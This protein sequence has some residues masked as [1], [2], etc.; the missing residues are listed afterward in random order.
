MFDFVRGWLNG[1]AVMLSTIT[2]VLSNLVSNVPAVLLLE[3]LIAKLTQPEAAWLTLAATSTLAGNLTLIGS[4]ANL[5][6]A[7]AALKRGV[8]LTFWEF[9]KSGFIITLISLV[10]GVGW[11]MVFVWK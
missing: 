2:V 8:K 9:T 6:V 1:G 5:I 11:L 10:L 4:V 7:E 3:P